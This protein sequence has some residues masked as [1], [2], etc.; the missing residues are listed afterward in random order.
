MSRVGIFEYRWGSANPDNLNVAF[1]ATN[2][3]FRTNPEHPPLI[4][5]FAHQ[6]GDWSME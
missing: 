5:S 6:K 1:K 3:R 2:C 4:R